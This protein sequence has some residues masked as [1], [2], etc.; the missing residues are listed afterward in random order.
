[1]LARRSSSFLP[2]DARL[3]RGLVIS[4]AVFSLG[5]N[6]VTL[7]LSALSWFFMLLGMTVSLG[8]I[9]AHDGRSQ[10]AQPIRRQPFDQPAVKRLS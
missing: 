7:W 2:H 4:L 5:V 6:S 10:L 9:R 1:M 8:A 3:V